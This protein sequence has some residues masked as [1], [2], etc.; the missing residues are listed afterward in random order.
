LKINCTELLHDFRRHEYANAVWRFL[1][2]IQKSEERGDE[3][4]SAK[5]AIEMIRILYYDERAA[6]CCIAIA[7]YSDE[8][9]M[10]CWVQKQLARRGGNS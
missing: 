8:D 4:L 1:G 6:G 7:D 2:S 3:W 9:V 5:D 10:R